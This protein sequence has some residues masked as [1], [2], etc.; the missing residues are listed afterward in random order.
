MAA[1]SAVP[2]CKAV[3][4]RPEASPASCPATPGERRGRGG[5]E[6]QAD[7]Q[8]AQEQP[9]EDVREV[10]AVYGDLGGHERPRGHERQAG[11]GGRPDAGRATGAD[12]D[13]IINLPGSFPAAAARSGARIVRAVGDAYTAA[14]GNW[15]SASRP[16]RP[17]GGVYTGWKRNVAW[18]EGAQDGDSRSALTG[19]GRGWRG[20]RGAVP[21]TKPSMEG[22]GS[23]PAPV[24]APPR[25]SRP[26]PTSDAR[27]RAGQRTP[28]PRHPVMRQ[29][30][31]TGR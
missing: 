30:V 28:D 25:T 26:P 21:L 24:P 19:A 17:P 11:R 27:H 8:A 23:V 9:D 4:L 1:P 7:P 12:S 31:V 13:S 2:V 20:V 6:G 3:L 5:H 29:Q 10:A 15:P 14:P 18:E 16:V 22:R